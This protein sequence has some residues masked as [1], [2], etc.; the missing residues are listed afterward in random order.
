L[1]ELDMLSSLFKRL[2]GDDGGQH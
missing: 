1:D 2:D